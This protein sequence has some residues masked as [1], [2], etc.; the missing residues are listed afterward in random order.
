MPNEY[1]ANREGNKIIDILARDKENRPVYRA[2]I[3]L[4]EISDDMYKQGF[5]F[6]GLILL[7]RGRTLISCS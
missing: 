4:N 1:I 3:H 6:T 7:P 5:G 2:E